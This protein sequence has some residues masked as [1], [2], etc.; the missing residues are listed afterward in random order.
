MQ[1]L[2]DWV[3]R[4]GIVDWEILRDAYVIDDSVDPPIYGFSVQYAPN[5]AWD[6]LVRAGRLRNG[7]V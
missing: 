6:D 5:M 7:Q 3:V 1:L 4:G 2:Q